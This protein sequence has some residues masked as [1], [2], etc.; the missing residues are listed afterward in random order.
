LRERRERKAIQWRYI[1]YFR[2]VARRAADRI[3]S[4][5]VEAGI[6]EARAEVENLDGALEYSLS[7][8][9]DVAA[10]ADIVIALHRFWVETGRLAEGRHWTDMALAAGLPMGPQVAQVL[11]A[12][13]AVAHF[14][15]DMVRLAELTERLVPYHENGQDTLALARAL[16]GLATASFHL[17][18]AERASKLFQRALKEY[19]KSGDRRGAAVVL[20]NLGALATETLSDVAGARALFTE[21]LTLFRE[22]GISP[23]TGIALSNLSAIS[24]IDGEYEQ[25]LAYAN[26]SLV[27]FERLGNITQATVALIHIAHARLER[28]EIELSRA[29]LIASR[30]RLRRE[31]TIRNAIDLYE[32]AFLFACDCGAFERA[33]ELL[34]IAEAVRQNHSLPRTALSLSESSTREREVRA[35]LGN[36]F[37]RHFESGRNAGP[38]EMDRV[39]D[40]VLSSAAGT[41]AGG[42]SR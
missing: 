16:N 26:E 37:D 18:D 21:S 36:L 28:G 33:G 13:A 38:A 9:V 34:G 31:P 11:S 23:Q 22:L 4:G 17:G 5:N 42:A 39:L 10:G 14:R 27:I 20:M 1:R 24:I 25:A 12:A 15:G 2:A 35:H 8:R 29:T 40:A 7:R 32:I 6:D 30:E 3:E 19:R 41:L